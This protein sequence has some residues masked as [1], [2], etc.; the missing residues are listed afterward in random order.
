MRFERGSVGV[1]VGKARV[2]LT[3]PRRAVKY[4]IEMGEVE[5]IWQSLLVDAMG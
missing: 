3:S 2:V 1:N 5:G 4:T